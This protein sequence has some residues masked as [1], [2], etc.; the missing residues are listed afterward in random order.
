MEFL[1]M[2]YYDYL[3]K[4]PLLLAI[5]ALI[6]WCFIGIDIYKQIPIFCIIGLFFT[7]K[8]KEIMT[9]SFKLKFALYFTILFAIRNLIILFLGMHDPW[10][11]VGIIT[12]LP[13]IIIA[14]PAQAIIAFISSY[15]SLLI[16]NRICLL[17]VKISELK[18]L[19]K[20]L[21][22]PFIFLV[23]QPQ[24]LISLLVI[25]Y[26]LN[27]GYS[28][29]FF[30][31]GKFEFAG[32][33]EQFGQDITS[34]IAL[35]NGDA[36]I[37][38]NSAGSNNNLYSIYNHKTK[39]ITFGNYLKQKYEILDTNPQAILLN[40]GKVLIV[41]ALL[42]KRRETDIIPKVTY[43]E[44]YDPETKSLTLTGA[45]LFPSYSFGMAKLNDGKILI[46]GG[47]GWDKNSEIYDPK[48]NKFIATGNLNFGRISPQLLT[49]ANG[50]VLVLGGAKDEENKNVELYEPKKRTFKVIGG[51]Y[52]VLYTFISQDAK[53]FTLD[54]NRVVILSY[55]ENDLR[56]SSE[57]KNKD[58]IPQLIFYN[59]NTNSF[60]IKNL[61]QLKNVIA[62]NAIPLNKNQ[63]LI[64]GGKIGLGRMKGYKILNRAGIYDIKTQKYTPIYNK[65]KIAR[66]EH[67]TVLLKDGNVLILR[68][69]ND[70]MRP[71]YIK[72]AELF[73]PAKQTNQ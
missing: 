41:G 45:N 69:F 5:V 51:K 61:N 30:N 59:L 10:G 54:K 58:N 2:K 68:G 57:P 4:S 31:K 26:L 35:N 62:F 67:N 20:Y 9:Q 36:F 11:A 33:I 46:T 44:L 53:A 21:T 24:Y 34:V 17:L 60:T 38:Q 65:M 71:F 23:E 39:K 3:L 73:V 49:L 52:P 47:A 48:T 19:A 8:N 29:I 64:T 32:T 6:T 15:L 16:S 66:S 14:L 1:I 55:R 42:R 63:I 37:L 43:G 28:L 56:G 12:A 22:K 25:I 72:Q 50:N 13:F 40:N 18:S 27:F 7:F 70:K